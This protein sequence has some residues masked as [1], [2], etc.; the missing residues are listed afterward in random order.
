MGFWGWGVG[1]F[2]YLGTYGFEN[3]Q[4]QG[5]VVLGIWGFRVSRSF[6]PIPEEKSVL[7]YLGISGPPRPHQIRAFRSSTPI[8]QAGE[9]A[10]LLVNC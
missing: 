5:F 10:L 4:I 3:L 8:G 9:A 7:S 6:P 2:R 1:L